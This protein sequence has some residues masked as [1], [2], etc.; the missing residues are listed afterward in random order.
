MTSGSIVESA[1]SYSW[2]RLGTARELREKGT[3][4]VGSRYQETA[5]DD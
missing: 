4:A 5:S 3:A 2:E 1:E